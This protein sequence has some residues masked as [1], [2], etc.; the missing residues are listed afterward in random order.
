VPVIFLFS[1]EWGNGVY[2]AV[3]LN[4]NDSNGL[5][6][7][8]I[9]KELVLAQYFPGL[10]KGESGEFSGMG[11]LSGSLSV[12]KLEGD[13]YLKK[14]SYAGREL[15]QF[16]FSARM[17]DWP[18]KPQS[19][20]AG[21]GGFK[22][23][24]ARLVLT[25]QSYLG[26]PDQERL[27]K[28]FTKE[29]AK[30]LSSDYRE[31]KAGERSLA[32]KL[33]MKDGS[34]NSLLALL[35]GELPG[36][37]YD[38]ELK[39]GALLVSGPVSRVRSRGRVHAANG[40]LAGYRFRELYG[41][42]EYAANKLEVRQLIAANETSSLSIDSGELIFEAK[43]SYRVNLACRG[44]KLRFLGVPLDGEL[45]LDGTYRIVNGKGEYRGKEKVVGL[46]VGNTELGDF[47]VD[48]MIR[49]R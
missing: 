5:D 47:V 39:I 6:G 37:K 29:E 25:G 27:Q 28:V 48:H 30:E 10:S 3:N 46:R 9:L 4:R 23:H 26:E 38:G 1:A 34:L 43:D 31:M 14:L 8:L 22:Y 7:K 42:F 17:L 21:E 32:L 13:Y 44:S 20:I 33:A 24:G 12:P 45:T 35:P 49:F 36:E 15:E 2:G 40:H 18:W 41:D 19:M 16:Y 11:E